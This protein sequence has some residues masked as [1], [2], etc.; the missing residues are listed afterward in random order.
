[1]FVATAQQWFAVCNN[2]FNFRDANVVCRQLGL[3]YPVNL[4]NE[5]RESTGGEDPVF[6]R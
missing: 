3:G 5:D 6:N 2:L 1:M 4:V